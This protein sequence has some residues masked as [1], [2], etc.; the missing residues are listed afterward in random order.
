MKLTDIKGIGPKKQENLTKLG[1]EDVNQLI[2]YLPRRYEDR[3]EL[4]YLAS[5]IDGEK[6]YFELEIMEKSR[7]YFVKKNMSITRLKAF[8][9]TGQVNLVWYND[10]YSPQSLLKGEIYKFFGIYDKEKKQLSNPLFAKLNEDYIGGIYPIYSIIKG[11]SNKELISFK[12]RVFE[13][14]KLKEDYL[15]DDVLRDNNLM[16]INSMYKVLH[17]PSSFMELYKAK[18]TYVVRQL[19]TEKLMEKFIEKDRGGS[20]KF[21]AV[22]LQRELS[23]LDFRLTQD[24]EQALT[25]ICHDMYSDTRMN[26]IVIGDV[27][28]GKTIVAILSSI[29]AIK[30]G[31]QVAFMAPTEL[32]AMQHFQNYKTYLDQLEISSAI[33]T[34]STKSDTR[35]DITEGIANGH[36]N[37]VFGTHALFQAKVNFCRLG[38][39]I[40]DEQQRFGVY[41]RKK[42]Y[43]KGQYP[44]TL[45]LSATP[46]PR[47]LALT[48]YKDLDLSLI[49][50]KPSNRR[51][52]QSYL[53]DESYEKRFLNFAYKQIQ[54]GRQV[55]VVCPRV[56]DDD[57]SDINSVEALYRAYRNYF[58]GK[59]RIDFLHGKLDNEV[60][61]KKQK[62]FQ[63]GLIDL[64]ISTTII[65]VGIDVKNA[66][67]MIIYDSN[68]F[69]L[70]QLHQLRG[71]IGR[72]EYQSYCIFVAKKD[73]IEDEKLKYIETGNDGFEIA[74]KDLELRGSGDRYGLFQSGFV[75]D[76]IYELYDADLYEIANNIADTLFE[77]KLYETNPSLKIEIEN[78]RLELE[79]IILN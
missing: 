26:R 39:V 22:S 20:I 31:Y 66:N 79:K 6:Q 78:K 68:N 75:D 42:L 46:I 27:G 51:E 14:I 64:L 23:L 17:K 52:I 19:T 16:D 60:K 58:K 44:D 45:L 25:E 2:S 62:L 48:I 35:R 12:D 76:N 54:E 33:L 41:Q 8:D 73:K 72:G 10:R 47:T 57:M 13:T 21:K 18:R 55:Y 70:S 3:S 53:V 74:E 36:I 1:I 49:R 15:S 77:E 59:I 7:T 69:G 56:E 43:D 4:V 30:N 67:L 11:L 71:R 40:T 32:L 50:H 29:I 65:E 28:S 24:Q 9:K 37:I 38:L 61:L 34:G 5:A 63:E